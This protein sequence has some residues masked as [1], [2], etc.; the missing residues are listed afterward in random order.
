MKIKS[1][2]S[3]KLKFN[4]EEEKEKIKEIILSEQTIFNF[5]SDL[6][7][8]RYKNYTNIKLIHDKIYNKA[9]KKYPNIPSQVVIKAQQSVLASYRTIRS[10]K[11]K[12]EKPIIK[13][14]PSLRLDDRLHTYEEKERKFKITTLDKRVYCELVGYDKINNMLDKYSFGDPLIYI[15]DNDIY[16]AL[17]FNVEE[18]EKEKEKEDN[19]NKKKLAVGVDLGIRR[20]AATSEGKIFKDEK[21][22]KR[23]RQIRHLKRSLQSKK[24]KSAKRHLKKIRKKEYN[25]SKNFCRHLAKSIVESTKANVFVLED[26]SKIKKGIKSKKPYK[27]LNQISQI[28]F[29]MLRQ[30]IEHKAQLNQKELITVNPHYT[31]QI[32][33]ITRTRSGKRNGCRY[34][35]KNGQ[36][37]DADV[38]AAIN[39]A[40][41]SKLPISSCKGLDGQAVVNRPIVG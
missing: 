10:N 7:Y 18:K 9:R 3:A 34:I 6:I 41:R 8:P 36:V 31:S 1:T 4:N 23:K 21:Y 24:T 30:C 11:H 17:T 2:W 29:Y 12:I 40:V 19:K 35:C 39:I 22:N 16:I 37:L 5:A 28:P 14:N 38:N 26:L 13:R 32:D 27:N 20:F 25:M 15:R 33:H